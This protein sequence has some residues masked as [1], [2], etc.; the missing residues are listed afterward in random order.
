MNALVKLAELHDH[1]N[2]RR[3]AGDLVSQKSSLDQTILIYVRKSDDIEVILALKDFVNYIIQKQQKESRIKTI[4]MERWA[5]EALQEN[6]KLI[7]YPIRFQEWLPASDREALEPF[8]ESESV[9]TKNKTP[10]TFIKFDF[11]YCIGG[12]GTLL[13]LLRF[14]FMWRHP[15]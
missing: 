3:L 6:I 5:M 14:L 9:I 1:N 4:Y 11:V 2:C 13:R 12:D 10:E 8:I 7:S 15:P